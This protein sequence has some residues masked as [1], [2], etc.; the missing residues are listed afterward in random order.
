MPSELSEQWRNDLIR[1]YCMVAMAC[2]LTSS[3]AT[4][5]TRELIRMLITSLR[6]S[7]DTMQHTPF[8]LGEWQHS[9]SFQL[10]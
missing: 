2:P 6:Y 3:S 5:P 9:R 1:S 7:S 10:G 8:N 4:I